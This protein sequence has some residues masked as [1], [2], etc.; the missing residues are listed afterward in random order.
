M[1]RTVMIA[2]CA[3]AGAAAASSTIG[4]LGRGE[5]I[6]SHGSWLGTAPGAEAAVWCS[7]KKWPARDLWNCGKR[8]RRSN[9]HL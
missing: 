7:T 3:G 8:R 6:A 4:A 1:A 2:L 5:Q 9:A